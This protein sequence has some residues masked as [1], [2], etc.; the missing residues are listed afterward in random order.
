MKQWV[1]KM[2]RR[3]DPIH[4]HPQLFFQTW[5]FDFQVRY[6]LEGFEGVP[7]KDVRKLCKLGEVSEKPSW[8]L[9]NVVTT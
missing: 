3:L 4:G 6:N 9:E 8:K 7:L 2:L 1:H 5:R